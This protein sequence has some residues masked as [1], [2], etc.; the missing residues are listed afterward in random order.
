[1]HN[2][3]RQ[4]CK[5]RRLLQIIAAAATRSSLDKPPPVVV[6]KQ[7]KAPARIP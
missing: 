2:L 6:G 5:A 4:S 3:Q 1:M 7:R